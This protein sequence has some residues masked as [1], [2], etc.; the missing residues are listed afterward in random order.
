[1][2]IEGVT[3]TGFELNLRD[4]FP[5]GYYSNFSPE[6]QILFNNELIALKEYLTKNK[7]SKFVVNITAGESR[8]T[9]KDNEAS[10][11]LLPEGGLA[12]KRAESLKQKLIQY[13]Q[14]LIDGRAAISQM[15]TFSEPVIELR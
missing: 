4:S 13:F 7:D 6:G 5:M 10:G 2:I 3:P 8:V 15:P 11:T 1:M 12:K 14:A 9:N